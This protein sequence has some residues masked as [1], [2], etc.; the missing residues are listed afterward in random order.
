MPKSKVFFDLGYTYT[1]IYTQAQI[2]YYQNAFGPPPTTQCPASLGYS[3]PAVP[4]LGSY[5]S[6]QHFV[7]ADITWKPEKRITATIGYA[8]TF[9]GGNTLAIDPLQVPGTLA[10]NYQKPYVRATYNLYKGLSY[11][12][13]WNYYGYNGR[14]QASNAIPG[15]AAIPIQDFNG[16]NV[17]FAFRYAF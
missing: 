3:P 15:L 1:D 9:V 13:T 2:C 17:E 14:G 11:R 5:S 8:G 10:F 12:M 7:Y 6:N 4:G 16:S